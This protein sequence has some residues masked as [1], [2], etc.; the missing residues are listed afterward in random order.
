MLI[1]STLRIVQRIVAYDRQEQ[2]FIALVV[3][4]DW[5]NCCL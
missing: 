1:G 5:M 3:K 2:L 4:C